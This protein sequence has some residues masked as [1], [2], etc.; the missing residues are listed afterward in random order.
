MFVRR[1]FTLVELLVVIAVLAL[2]AAILLPVFAKARESARK[3]SCQTNLRQIGVAF[4]LYTTDYDEHYPC[5]GDPNLWMGRNW[6]VVIQ[7]YLPGSTI[8]SL[9]PGYGQPLSVRHSDILLC[10]S[11]ERAVQVWERTS[12]AYSATFFHTPAQ[13]DSLEPLLQ[14]SRCEN[15]NVIVSALR[16]LPTVAQREAQVK[17]PTQKA[18]CAEWL[19]N[20]EKFNNDCGFW[21]WDGSANYLFADGHVKFLRRRQI[22]P[23]VNELPDINLT[24]NGIAGSDIGQ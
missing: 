18:L 12:Y 9:P 16:G 22:N 1:A 24:R 2:L 3:A 19:S 21:S 8:T 20:H 23:A 5:N 10:P 11:D 14:G 6:R 15:W 7:T 4:R 13:I 17:H